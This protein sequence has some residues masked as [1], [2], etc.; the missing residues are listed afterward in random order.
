MLTEEFG[1]DRVKKGMHPDIYP[2]N[3]FVGNYLRLDVLT[4][5]G[6][7]ERCLQEIEGY[8]YYMA[9]KTGTL[10]ENITDYASCNHGFASYAAYL[11]D[12]NI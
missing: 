3:A 2:A 9:E 7:K 11:I 4:R 1:P 12:K 8:F 10:W 5:Y 6:L